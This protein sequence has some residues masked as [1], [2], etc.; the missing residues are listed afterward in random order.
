MQLVNLL[1]KLSLDPSNL[2]RAAV[3]KETQSG[4]PTLMIKALKTT[5]CF[6]LDRTVCIF[7]QEDGVVF[8]VDPICDKHCTSSVLF[9]YI[10]ASNVI[11]EKYG[12]SVTFQGTEL[13]YTGTDSISVFMDMF[14]Y[15]LY[16]R[17]DSLLYQHELLRDMM[18][19]MRYQR[20]YSRAALWLYPISDEV[21]GVDTPFGTL[22]S[23][24]EKGLLLAK[25]NF[26]YIRIRGAMK[27]I[28]G[29]YGHIP[30]FVLNKDKGRFSE[31]EDVLLYMDRP[32][33]SS[34]VTSAITGFLSLF[35]SNEYITK[36]NYESITRFP[37]IPPAIPRGGNHVVVDNVHGVLRR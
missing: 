14:I 36:S 5:N 37:S 35:Y 12:D 21:I 20:V 24:D 9:N 6:I 33:V 34:S 19:S 13:T 1:R 4:H 3:P 15:Y 22:Y 30:D 32:G 28:E 25:M 2:I 18:A 26:T 23:G 17:C 29:M 8:H 27:V 11:Q 7:V 10:S 31:K 16:P